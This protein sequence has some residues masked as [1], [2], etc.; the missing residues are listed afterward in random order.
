MHFTD[1]VYRNPYWPTYP[2]LQITQGC[3]HNR[4]K[5]CSMYKGVPFRMQPMDLIEQDLMELSA[6]VPHARTIQL[7]SAN[8]LALTYDKLVPIL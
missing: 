4:C 1:P 8:P 7:L 6:T 5:F 3:T 2:L